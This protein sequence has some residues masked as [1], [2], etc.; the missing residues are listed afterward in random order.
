MKGFIGFTDGP[1]SMTPIPEAFFLDLLPHMDDP[2]EIKLSLLLIW[3]LAQQEGRFRFLALTAIKSD[4]D[5]LRTISADHLDDALA[6]AVARGTFL[7]VNQDSPDREAF[8]FLNSQRGRAAARGLAEGKWNPFKEMP[9]EPPRIQRPNIFVLYEQ[10]IG[11]LTPLIA[12][13]IRNA[14]EEYSDQEVTVAI[15]AAVEQNA[16]SWRYIE[17]VLE[18]RASEAR[19]PKIGQD[20]EE[21]RKYVE[22]K[23][24]DFIEH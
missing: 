7:L 23:Y 10:N 11:P 19:G 16:R 8:F 22:G 14:A 17:A 18:G 3:R 13:L 12:D 21:R 2:D 5:I 15:Q 20:A 6:R 4:P 24:S 9:I 1:S